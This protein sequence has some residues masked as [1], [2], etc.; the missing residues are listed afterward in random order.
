[1]AWGG[2]QTDKTAES[3][4]EF[5]AELRALAG[6]KP[7]SAE[8]LA[9][10]RANHVRGYA[11]RFESLG[12]VTDLAGELWVHGLPM[13]ELQRECDETEKATLE[14][15]NAAAQR[16]AVPERSALLLVGDRARI[17]D[18]VRKL[19]LGEIVVLGVE[20]EPVASN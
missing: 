8:E 6:Q 12:R 2:V 3:V 18:G 7:I 17:E 13:T 4:A 11:Q 9:A 16:Y 5:V 15:V 20:G 10:A 14:A 19:G 1:M